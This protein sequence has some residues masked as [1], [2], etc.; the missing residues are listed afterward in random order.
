MSEKKHLPFFGVG[1]IY[2]AIIAA[3]T[4]AGMLL[5][6]SALL[7]G[8]AVPALKTPLLVAGILL[9]LLG[10]CIWGAGFFLSRIDEGIRN[11]RLVTDGIY[12]WVRNPLY[13][14]W[15]FVCIGVLLFAANLWLLLLPL[16]F[17]WLMAF[18]MK[19]TE[20]KWLHDLYGAEYDA[21]CRRVNRTWPWPPRR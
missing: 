5:S 10:L 2:I 4:A 13:V 14:G 6:R 17:W 20:E 8:G 3:A 16:F 18:M 15:M 9:I 7:A 21:Y 1:P 12:A 19:R 11:N